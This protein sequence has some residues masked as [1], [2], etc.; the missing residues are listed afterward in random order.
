MEKRRDKPLVFTSS[1]GRFLVPAPYK[2]KP[3]Q[4]YE[5]FV[6]SVVQEIRSQ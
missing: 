2:T 4:K 3:S 6:V 5:G 1:R